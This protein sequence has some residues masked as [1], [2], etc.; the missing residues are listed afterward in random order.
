[1][2]G[3]GGFDGFVWQFVAEL[4]EAVEILDG[5]A[6]EAFGL[7]LVAEEEGEGGGGG[8]KLVEAFGEEVVA[9]LGADDAGILVDEVGADADEG[10]AVVGHGLVEADGEEAGVEAFGAEQGMLGEGDAFDGEGFLGVDGPVDG[11]GVG[12]EVGDVVDFLEADDGECGGVEDVLAC[13]LGGAGLAL[14]GAGSGGAGAL[15]RLAASC[16]GEMFDIGSYWFG[17]SISDAGV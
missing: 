15:A 2:F 12:E 14:G 7:G 5:A 13:V 11:D 6:V 4:A 10:A 1:M 9:I 17:C 16:L 8:G 3:L